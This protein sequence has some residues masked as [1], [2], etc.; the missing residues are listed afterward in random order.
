MP[1]PQA[2]QGQRIPAARKQKQIRLPSFSLIRF[3]SQKQYV[4]FH[5]ASARQ[6]FRRLAVRPVADHHQFRG[7]FLTHQVNISTASKM[8]FTGRKFERCIRIGS[9][10]EPTPPEAWGRLP[11]I[12]ITVHKIRNHFDWPLDPKFRNRLPQQIAEIEVTPSLC[13]IEY[14]VIGKKLGLLPTRVMSVPCSVVINGSR[15][16]AAICRASN[17]LTECG[18]A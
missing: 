8:R 11:N 7:H 9:P 3:V 12:Q 16:G 13:S 2:P 18:I 1:W 5:A 4:F 6:R 14:R 15:R 17:A 10:S